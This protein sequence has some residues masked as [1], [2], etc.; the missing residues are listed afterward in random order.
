[1]KRRRRRRAPPETTPDLF[2]YVAPVPS[3]PARADDPETSHAAAAR[4]AS[5]DVG[6]FSSKTR[7]AKLLIEFDAVAPGGLTHFEAMRRVMSPNEFH[8]RLEGC[9]R[10]CSDLKAAGFIEAH[11]GIDGKPEKRRNP[12]SPDD[13]IIWFITEAGRTAIAR[14]L[15][16]GW[17]R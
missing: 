13:S 5:K 4:V 8:P 9:R 7:Q 6:R 12:G 11:L 1:M 2:Q 10:R 14:L 16:T 3:H 17:S 15:A